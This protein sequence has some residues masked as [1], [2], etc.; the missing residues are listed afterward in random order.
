MLLNGIVSLLLLV[1]CVS[2]VSEDVSA[3][4]IILR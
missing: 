2:G 3:V 4:G 1:L